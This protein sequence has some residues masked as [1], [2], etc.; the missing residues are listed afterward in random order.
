MGG[1][2]GNHLTVAKALEIAKDPNQATPPTATTVLER[3]INDI[4]RSIQAQPNSYVMNKEEFAVFN[5]FRG[6]YNNSTAQQAVSR[7]WNNYKG[8][9]QSPKLDG[10]RPSAS[11][12]SS[13]SGA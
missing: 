1:T 3:R 9:A 11:S 12:T 10:S 4:W 2:S 6:R 13:T 7:F 8:D 5:H